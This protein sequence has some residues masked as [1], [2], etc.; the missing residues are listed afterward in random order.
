MAVQPIGPAGSGGLGPMTIQVVATGN[1]QNIPLFS[2]F[3]S[4]Y[5]PLFQN[6]QT[7][8]AAGDTVLTVPTGASVFYM[9]LPAGNTFAVGVRTNGAG[10]STPGILI[11]KLGFICLSIDPSV[12]TITI[13]NAG[14]S[15]IVGCPV[16]FL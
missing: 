13:N 11:N 1:G 6:A 2:Q 16:L 7:L 5:S 12:T 8:G 10:Q 14:A 9:S 4:L 3:T 15:T